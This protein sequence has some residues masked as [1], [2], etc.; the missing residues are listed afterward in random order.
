MTVDVDAPNSFAFH[1]LS[2]ST[3]PFHLAWA[4]FGRSPGSHMGGGVRRAGRAMFS[5]V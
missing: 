5:C 3:T 4:T 2:F 1:K